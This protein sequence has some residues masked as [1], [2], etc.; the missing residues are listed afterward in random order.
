MAPCRPGCRAA[1]QAPFGRSPTGIFRGPSSAGAGASR[2][3]GHRSRLP[4]SAWP[5]R[6]LPRPRTSGS[7]GRR[8]ARFRLFTSSAEQ[9][10]IGRAA[11]GMALSRGSGSSGSASPEAAGPIERAVGGQPES[12]GRSQPEA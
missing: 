8:G 9:N 10:F 11:P 7:A 3:L 2:R 4:V 5:A 1:G 6:C 12:F